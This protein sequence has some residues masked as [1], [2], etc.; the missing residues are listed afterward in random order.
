[1]FNKASLLFAVTLAVAATASPT[2]SPAPPATRGTTI[3]LRKR[4][5]MKTSTGVFDKE[6]ALFDASYMMHKHRQNLMNLVN[7]VGAGALNVGA[8]IRPLSNISE[9]IA[10]RRVER[11]QAETLTDEEEDLEWAGTISVGTPPQ[12]FLIDFDTGSSDLWIPSSS[13]TSSTCSS[14]AKFKA[15]SSS[16]AAK[17]SGKFSI[18]Y[19]DGSTV[20]G[21]VYTDTVNVAGINVTKQFFSPVT[22]LS[23]SFS[24]DPIDGILGLAFPAISNMKQNPFFNTANE[25]GVVQNNQFGFFLA[26]KGSELFLGG[27]D[28]EKYTGDLEFHDV[29]SSSGFWQVTGANAKVGDAVAAKNFDTIIDSGTTIMYG[30]PAAVKKLYAAVDGSKLF[31]AENG[32]YSFPCDTPPKIAF[33]WGGEDWVISAENINIGQTEEGSSDCVGALAGVDTGLGSNVWLL[34]DSFMKNVYTAFDFDQKAVG[35]AA[36]A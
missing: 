26:S 2:V 6:K 19:G 24:T 13:C 11:R 27:T 3:P 15:S 23:S 20:S 4:T 31:D 18:Q 10:Q 14:K 35:F 36:I 16:T 8:V 34:G 12:K 9:I 21:P 1:M 30:P 28:T 25:Q 33:N 7:N 32:Y 29:D 5:S 17:Q 22:T